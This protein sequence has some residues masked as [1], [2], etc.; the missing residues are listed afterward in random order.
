MYI[1]L[2]VLM[3]LRRFVMVA[4]PKEDEISPALESPR[5]FLG[6]P[7]CGKLGL[8]S[9]RRRSLFDEDRPLLPLAE[10]NLARGGCHLL[11]P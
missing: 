9:E 5:S 4:E 2:Q 1:T 6:E 8:I 3:R 7:A 11:P 10:E